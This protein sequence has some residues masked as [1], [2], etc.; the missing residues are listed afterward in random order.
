MRQMT[1][2]RRLGSKSRLLGVALAAALL[3]AACA[4]PFDTDVENPN[5][6]VEEALGDAAGATTLVNG[7][8]GSVTRA[9]TGIYGPY[10]TA[11]DELTWVGSRE[12][13]KWLDDGDISDPVNEYTDGAF[14]F[15]AEARWL[16]DFT[17]ARVAGFDADGVLR[18]RKDLA[19]ANIYGAVIY[20]TIGDMFED[21]VVASDRTVAAAPVGPANMGAMYDSAI[22]MASRAL[23]IAQATAD[24]ELQ[25]QALGLRARARH[26]KAARAITKAGAG[27]NS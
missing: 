7:L 17:I 16:A 12:F 26:A 23:T 19:R 3:P 8:G 21:F 2:M 14:P 5:A 15:V 24:A 27:A 22:T 10:H 25:R 9:L 20:T 6:V 18:N 11:T 4:N 13:W 1:S